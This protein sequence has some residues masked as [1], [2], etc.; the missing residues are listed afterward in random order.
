MCDLYIDLNSSLCWPLLEHILILAG[1][2]YN[3]FCKTSNL[4]GREER[5]SGENRKHVPLP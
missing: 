3:P 2:A 4:G 1:H 5:L